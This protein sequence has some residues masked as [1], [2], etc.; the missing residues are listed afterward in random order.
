MRAKVEPILGVMKG[1]FGVT[2]VRY[3][4]L[5]KNAHHLFVSCALVNLVMATK[6]FI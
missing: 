6:T 4:G 5:A 1:R 2:R 3:K